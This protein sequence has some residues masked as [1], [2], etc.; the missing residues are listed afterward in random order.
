MKLPKPAPERITTSNY[1]RTHP[2]MLRDR[3]DDLQV[4]IDYKDVKN[5]FTLR[6]LDPFFN[7]LVEQQFLQ[8]TC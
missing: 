5:R 7:R 8:L 1:Q 4:W 6:G 2:S 3:V